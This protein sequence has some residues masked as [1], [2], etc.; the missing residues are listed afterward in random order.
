MERFFRV[1]TT[2]CLAPSKQDNYIINYKTTAITPATRRAIEKEWRYTTDPHLPRRAAPDFRLREDSD[3]HM[4][5]Q[6]QR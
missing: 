1:P 2:A 3:E 5:L 4:G 6:L